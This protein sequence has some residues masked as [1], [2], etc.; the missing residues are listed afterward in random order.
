MTR[1]LKVSNLTSPAEVRKSYTGVGGRGEGGGGSDPAGSGC[2]VCVWPKWVT[3][4]LIT[5]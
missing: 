4:S 2:S 1:T 3:D 5:F